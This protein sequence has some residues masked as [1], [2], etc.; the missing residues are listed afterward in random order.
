[1][2]SEQALG[3]QLDV[4]SDLFTLGLIFYE[5][6]T[7]KMRLAADSALA[8]LIKRTQERAMPVTQHDKSIPA[9]LANIVAKCME[10]DP[11]LRYQSC[12]QL[13]NDLEGWQGKRAAATLAFNA[14]VGPFARTLPWPAIGIG[15]AVIVL[16]IVGF[17]L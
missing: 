16:A 9:P 10:R 1:M 7:G 13:L 4:R 11:K 15:V 3:S 5:L 14:S 8:S 12:S 2:S 6:L 17:L